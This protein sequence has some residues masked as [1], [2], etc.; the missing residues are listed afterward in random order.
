V[1]AARDALRTLVELREA[2]SP[3]LRLPLGADEVGD[4]W[5]NDGDHLVNG[6]GRLEPADA[7]FIAA[8]AN[9]AFLHA[10]A[11]LAEDASMDA[12]ADAEFDQAS[13]FPEEV[14]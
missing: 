11:L 2:A 7:A 3:W 5:M 10:E 14:T 12:E 6:A 1:S 13:E 8:A 9:F 4:I